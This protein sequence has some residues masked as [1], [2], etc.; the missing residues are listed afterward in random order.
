MS[1]FFF[2]L[3]FFNEISRDVSDSYVLS[4][5]RW[6]YSCSQLGFLRLSGYFNSILS[7]HKKIK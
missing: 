7:V 4:Y 6:E 1:V 2:F 5:H 3:F